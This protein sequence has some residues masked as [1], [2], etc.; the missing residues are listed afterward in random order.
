[1]VAAETAALL[2]E[3]FPAE[4]ARLPGVAAFVR[5]GD[6]DVNGLAAGDV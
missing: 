2:F 3:F 4:V 1:M 5:R 6:L